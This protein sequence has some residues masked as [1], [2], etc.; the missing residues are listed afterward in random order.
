M[1]V[2]VN[3]VT[4]ICVMAG[5]YFEG[6][7]GLQQ[8]HTRAMELYARAAELGSRHAHF[9]LGSIY[10]QGGGFEE[11]QIPLRGRSYGWT[12]SG[13]IQPGWTRSGKIPRIS[14]GTKGK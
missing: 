12:R 7:G 4:S 10:Y 1:P 5:Y 9:E 2:E 3:D 8:D 11:G 13:K 6:T 14:G